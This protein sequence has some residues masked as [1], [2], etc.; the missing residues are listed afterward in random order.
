MRPAGSGRARSRT[1]RRTRSDGCSNS[2]PT[3]GIPDGIEI[4]L[5]GLLWCAFWDGAQVVAF[6]DTGTPRIELPVPAPRPTSNAF[7]GP[8]L[9]TLF[10]TSA[11]HG[12]P[13]ET[14]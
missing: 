10:V 2:T 7:G 1:A 14:L 6:D 13:A 3:C 4:D 8:D 5:D 12:L 9:R 11:T